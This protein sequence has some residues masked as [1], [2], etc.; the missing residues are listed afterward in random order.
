M[1]ASQMVSRVISFTLLATMFVFV[2]L[3]HKEACSIWSL[4]GFVGFVEFT[5]LIAKHG[6]NAYKLHI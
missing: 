2:D 5:T 4:V 1:F 6:L 3:K